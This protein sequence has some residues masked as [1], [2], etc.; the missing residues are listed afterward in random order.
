MNVSLPK[1]LA[2]HEI[3]LIVIDS[4]GAIFRT[5]T[6]D[7]FLRALDMRNLASSLLDLSNKYS[8][9]AVICV[10]QVNYINLNLKTK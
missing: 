3:G 6:S 2:E 10:N 4:V 8:P 7:S 5:E 1:L 9:C